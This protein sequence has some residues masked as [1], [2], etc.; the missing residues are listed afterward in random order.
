MQII[1]IVDS[2]FE[3]TSDAI[4]REAAEE[5]DDN[6]T[7]AS[8]AVDTVKAVAADKMYKNVQAVVFLINPLSDTSLTYVKEQVVNV[9][10]DMDIL[11]LMVITLKMKNR[12]LKKKLMKIHSF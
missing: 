8:D 1:D 12:K 2:N 5:K 11:I 4:L 7:N 6:G 9:P 10:E 3:R